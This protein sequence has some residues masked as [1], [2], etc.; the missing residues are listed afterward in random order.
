[1]AGLMLQKDKKKLRHGLDRTRC[2][3]TQISEHS[4]KESGRADLEEA[5]NQ[6]CPVSEDT[7]SGLERCI[8]QRSCKVTLISN[9]WSV[10]TSRYPA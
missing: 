5:S 9:V 7:K 6:Q 1:M 4:F 10:E 8:E 3:D 2:R